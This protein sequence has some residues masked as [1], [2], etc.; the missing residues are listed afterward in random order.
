MTWTPRLTLGAASALIVLTNAF[1]LA[2]VAYNRSGDPESTLHLSERELAVPYEW[3]LAKEKS[4]ISLDITWRVAPPADEREQHARY[5]QHGWGVAQWLTAAKLAELGFKVPPPGEEFEADAVGRRQ[6]EREVYLV[7]EMDGPAYQDA[8]RA[9]RERLGRAEA[10][11]TGAEL[12]KSARDALDRELASNSRL[13][14]IDAGLNSQAL[15][16]RYVDRA[17]FAVV[18][19]RVQPTVVGAEGKRRVLGSV[20]T[21]SVERIN[22]P[23]AFRQVFDALGPTR[24]YGRDAQLPR[25]EAT[26]AYGRR[27]EPWL[28]SAQPLLAK[29]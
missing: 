13:F 10:A 21:L 29:Q 12:A 28:V 16:T 11:A 20:R 24:T 27:L 17:R 26:V 9:A 7:L 23:L 4:A 8:L 1:V 5:Y 25:F 18:T 3:G 14:V 2:G 19:G 6:R 22:V 15:R